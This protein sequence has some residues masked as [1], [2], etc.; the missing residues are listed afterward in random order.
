V[1]RYEN[2]GRKIRWK[3]KKIWEIQEKQ[4]N[5]L[6]FDLFFFH[7]CHIISQFKLLFFRISHIF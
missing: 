2:Y 4:W 3:V 7:I 1:K 6:V 5:N